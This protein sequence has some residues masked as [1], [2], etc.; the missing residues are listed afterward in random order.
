MDDDEIFTDA[1][2]MGPTHGSFVVMIARGIGVVVAIAV[3]IVRVDALQNFFFSCSKL[4]CIQSGLLMLSFLRMSLAAL[5]HTV[6]ISVVLVSW[7]TMLHFGMK[8]SRVSWDSFL[9]AFVNAC[10]WALRSLTS[11]VTHFS[12]RSLIRLPSLWSATFC[13]LTTLCFWCDTAMLVLT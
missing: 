1:E 13:S 7:V 8:R 9:N 3:I 2:I 10:A 12:V 5:I 4:F 11:L 6:G